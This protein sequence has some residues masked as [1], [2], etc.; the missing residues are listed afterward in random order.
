MNWSKPSRNQESRSAG[1]T[2][3]EL[4]VVIAIIAIL[5]SML[6][7]ALGNAKAR[8]NSTLC[9]GNERQLGIAL[10]L[11]SNDSG[12]WFPPIQD[13]IPG[14]ESSWR[15]YLYQY[16]GKNPRLYDCP[17]EKNE[18]YAS[19]KPRPGA[20]PSPWVLGQFTP[21]EIDIP[22]GIGA[23]NVHWQ[24]GGAQPPFGRP[25][26]Y[27]NN[28][29]RWVFVESP[30]RLIVFGDGNGDTFGVWPQDRWWIWKEIG[31][32]NA[33]GFNRVAQGDK[34]AIRHL[35]KSNSAFADGSARLL[36][37]GRIPCNS[38]EC[39]WSAKATPH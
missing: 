34:G 33:P 16:L 10:H 4:L 21:G 18:V 8:A 26:G 37:A 14:G 9:L 30:S 2:L 7:P 35:R 23:V 31:S 32:A 19:A 13:R 12:D 6:L 15:A 11:Y 3:V 24:F 5:A 36:D 38:A 25:L 28:V 27:E 22:S 39:W 29:C 20:R 1:F 17:A